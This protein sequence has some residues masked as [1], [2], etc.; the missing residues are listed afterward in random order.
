MYKSCKTSS[1]KR[2]NKPCILLSNYSRSFL[3]Q[4]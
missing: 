1:N 2:S 3:Y 4:I